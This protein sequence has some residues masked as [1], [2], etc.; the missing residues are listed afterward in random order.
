M[1]ITLRLSF[2]TFPHE[3][4]PDTPQRY[5]ATAGLTCRHHPIIAISTS[6]SPLKN[7]LPQHGSQD[8]NN[9]SLFILHVSLNLYPATPRKSSQREPRPG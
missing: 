7:H 3:T 8:Y 5:P 9:K 4:Q 2:A 6:K 1:K